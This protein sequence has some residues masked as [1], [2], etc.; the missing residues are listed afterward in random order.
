MM[1]GDVRLRLRPDGRRAVV[2]LD[3]D[4]SAERAGTEHDHDDMDH[5]APPQLSR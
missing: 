1:L 3:L 4:R 2:H 5:F